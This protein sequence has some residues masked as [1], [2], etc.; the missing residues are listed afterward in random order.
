MTVRSLVAMR[1]ILTGVER[2]LDVE[3]MSACATVS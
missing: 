2:S 1:K 3:R